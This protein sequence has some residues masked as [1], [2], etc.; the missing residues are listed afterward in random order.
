LTSS[1][2]SDISLN[3]KRFGAFFDANIF[4]FPISSYQVVG[5]NND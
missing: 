5:A 3:K 2:A 4:I 1:V